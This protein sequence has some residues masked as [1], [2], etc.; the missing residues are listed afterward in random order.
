MGRVCILTDGTAQFI[1]SK[2]PGHDLVYTIPVGKPSTGVK[3]GGI[4]RRPSLPTV[5]DFLSH[6]MLLSAEYD[7]ILVLTLASSLGN[8]LENALQAAGKYVGSMDIQVIDSQTTDV[9]LGL[10][11]QKAAEM[12]YHG[13]DLN[14]IEDAMRVAIQHTYTLLCIPELRYLTR[15]GYLNHS[16]AVAGEV[17][18]MTPVLTVEEGGLGI[19]EKARTRRHLFEMLQEFLG[20]FNHPWYIAMLKAVK[21]DFCRMRPLR[22]YL[23]EAFPETQISERSINPYLATMI[24]PRSAGLIVV[25]HLDENLP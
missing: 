8:V 6:F 5:D 17:I 22:R 14:E 7:A 16:Q 20:E 13:A 23:N 4:S 1:D 25:E 24:G 12:A 19:I 11:A 2:F 3:W 9:G 21:G 10:L 15:S 18:G